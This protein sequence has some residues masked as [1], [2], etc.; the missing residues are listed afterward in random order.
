MR[1]QQAALN[2]ALRLRS[3]GEVAAT[4]AHEISQPLTALNTY[5]GLVTKAVHD[6]DFELA[7]RAASKIESASSRAATILTNMKEFLRQGTISRDEMDLRES[8]AELQDL[9][10]EDLSKRHISLV[11]DVC[12]DMPVLSADRI[13]LQQAVHNLIV[14]SAEAIQA[15][16]RHGRIVVTAGIQSGDT[17]AI[18]I[19]DD[20]PGFPSGYNLKDP[21]PF[22]ST[23]PEGSGLG[24]GVARSIAEAHGGCL[25]IT[26][27]SRGATVVLRIPIAER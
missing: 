4:I 17:C 2:R 3:A 12:Q 23:K 8:L 14:N 24:L 27:S 7:I 15:D 1:D 18:Q 6:R 9:L 21:T 20:G 22:T 11:I 10:K 19:S 13:Q 26:S 5:A 16:G 25:T